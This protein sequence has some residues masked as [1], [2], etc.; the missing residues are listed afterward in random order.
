M[1]KKKKKTSLGFWSPLF[2]EGCHTA[3]LEYSFCV[4]KFKSFSS[5]DLAPNQIKFKRYKR[6][7]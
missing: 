1:N 4:F 3:F 2:K 6:I 7:N 5:C